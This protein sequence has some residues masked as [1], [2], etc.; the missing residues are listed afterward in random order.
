MI[1]SLRLRSSVSQND[2]GQAFLNL[3][4]FM[5]KT[6]DLKAVRR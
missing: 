4:S 3:S 6:T 5:P 1:F 2:I